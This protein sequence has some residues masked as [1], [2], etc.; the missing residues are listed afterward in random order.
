MLTILILIASIIG[1]GGKPEDADVSDEE[2]ALALL[3]QAGE[4]VVVGEAEQFEEEILPSFQKEIGE[5]VDIR[6][7][8]LVLETKSID[9]VVQGTLIRDKVDITSTPVV[10]YSVEDVEISDFAIAEDDTPLSIEDWSPTGEL[11]IENRKPTI[12]VVF[13]HPIVPIRQLGDPITD[14]PHMRIDPQAPGIFRWYGTRVLSF[15]PDEPLL[16]QRVYT[17]QISKDIESLG[18]KQL[19]ED[20][21]FSFTTEPLGVVDF[22]CGTF[23]DYWTNLSNVPPDFANTIYIGFNQP[24]DMNFV[25]QFIE[26]SAGGR[27]Y[28]F[29]VSRPRSDQQNLVENLVDR[30]L[31]LTLDRGVPK[32]TDVT[33]RFVSGIRSYED[34][35]P[36]KTEITREY[37][38]LRPLEYQYFNT[39]SYSFPRD[40]RGTIN[41]VFLIF[42]QPI[43]EDDA[44]GYIRTS[45]D[46][47]D[48]ADHIK[49]SSNVVRIDNLP[50]VYES[51]YEI[52]IGGGL[53]DVYG[54][55]LS[56]DEKISIRVP[57]APYYVKFPVYQ[58]NDVQM[59]ML[60]SQFAPK[61]I[62]EFQNIDSG[63]L[64]VGNAAV[65]RG[66][67]GPA[68][69][70]AWTEIPFSTFP[71]NQ[72]NFQT[73][74][75]AGYTDAY[76][77]WEID[78]PGSE[79]YPY[80]ASMAVQITDIGITVK[81]AYNSIL[82]WATSLS[83]AEAVYP[84]T[85]TLY[86]ANGETFSSPV[87]RNGLAAFELSPGQYRRQFVD[88]YGRPDFL[89]AVESTKGKGDS[90][91]FR[92]SQSHSPY[93][94]SV[95]STKQPGRIEDKQR[96]VFMFTDRGLYKPGEKVTF[97]GV[98]WIQKLD[99]FYP[100][101][102]GYK[103]EIK[104]NP[105][106][107]EVIY[108][109]TGTT[110]S[111]GGYFGSF[112]VPEDL[113]PGN[114]QIIYT[115][116]GDSQYH[117][118]GFQVAFFRRLNFQVRIRK[119]DRP[120]FHGDRI[121]LPAQASYLA[122]GAMPEASY[123]F[124]FT[125]QPVGFV[126]P[127]SMWKDYR[128]GPVS[129]ESARN[130]SSGSGRLNALGAATLE[131]ETTE[132]GIVGKAYQYSAE[133]TVE[134][135]DRQRVSASSSAIVHPGAFYIGL[136]LDSGTDG[137][138]STFVSAKEKS[139]AEVVLAQ[140]DGKPYKSDTEIEAVLI[141]Q[142][143]KSVQQRGVYGNLNTRY[144][145][146]SEEVDTQT[147]R[148]R[149]VPVSFNFTPPEAGRYTLK[150]S[151]VD[152]KDRVI[153]TELV[154]YATGSSWV[155]WSTSNDSDINLV[156]DREAYDVG[157]VA[158]LM[159]QSPIPD[160]DY[161]LT[162]EREGIFEHRIVS[163]EGS[164]SVID[165]P[166]TGEH[167]P[168]VYVSLTAV[169]KREQTPASY[170]DPDLG[171][172]KNYYGITA[173]RVSTRPKELD[174]EIIPSKGAYRPGDEAE[175]L[176]RVTRDGKP[177]PGAEVTFLAVDRGVLDLIDY[178]VPDPIA[179][180]Y[181]ESH[182]PLGVYGDDSRRLLLAPVTYDIKN[183][184]GGDDD[185]GGKL[186]RREDFVPLAVFEPF[187]HTDNKGYV[188]VSFTLPDTLTTYRAT[189][190]AFEESRLGLEEEEFLVQN[191][192]NVRTALPRR[193]RYRDTAAAGVVLQNLDNV[194]H[195]VTVSLETT[196]LMLPGETEKTVTVPGGSVY[197]VPFLLSADR[198]GEFELK[199]TILSDVLKEELIDTLIVERPLVREA[200]TT[201]G[202]AT[203][204][205]EDNISFFEEGLVLPSAIASNFG[206]LRIQLDSTQIPYLNK[207]LSDLFGY[208]GYSWVMGHGYN[209]LAG[210]LF[211]E[212]ADELL[213]VSMERVRG[214]VREY[215]EIAS[216]YQ[217]SDGGIKSSHRSRGSSLY[218]SLQVAHY[219]ALAREN[220]SYDPQT[221]NTSALISYLKTQRDEKRI[222]LHGLS[223][224]LYIFSLYGETAAS[225]I[226]ATLEENGDALGI[227]G[228]SYLALS[229]IELGETAKAEEIFRRLKNFVLIGTQSVDVLETY[230]TRYYYDS[231]VQQI[232]LMLQIA[233]LLGERPDT[234]QRFVN[235]V[236]ARSSSARWSSMYDKTF[237]VLAMHAVYKK[238]TAEESNFEARVVLNN[239]L[240]GTDSFEGLSLQPRVMDYQLQ[241]DPLASFKRDALFP[242]RFEK[243]GPGN[244]FYATTLTYALPSEIVIARDEGISV[245]VQIE[246]LS[247][248]V[249]DGDN[250]PLG[251]TFK[252]RIHIS[253]SKR[254]ADLNLTV[255]VPSGAEIIDA[256][257]TTTSA[258]SEAGG[259]GSNTTTRETVYGDEYSFSGAWDWYYRPNMIIYD[260][261]VVYEWM[262]FHRGSKEVTFLF[263]TTTPGIY[264][265]PPAMA[266]LMFEP[267]VFGRS[268][269]RI[270]R[271]E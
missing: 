240:L 234:V 269:G 38:T 111:S 138:W 76:V 15:E 67:Y 10:Y 168:V 47:T 191:P 228:L 164:A 202:S 13:S 56:K 3:D 212:V 250:L 5:A 58:S 179:Y 90:A 197:E 264:P 196:G 245:H 218:S 208:Y 101:Q 65:D 84:A 80:K 160:A 1:C 221:L 69:E 149:G 185:D 249:I 143:W 86:S 7:F 52:Y 265:T 214:E 77:S 112:I 141:H 232:S 271:I 66:L 44:A 68:D 252:A 198:E 203:I 215:F 217:F 175:V 209:A 2:Q 225:E 173:L 162:V 105:W 75:L 103:I 152:K 14:F 171:K 123:T 53:T 6:S 247:G 251:E 126:P 189:A 102:G 259:T 243:E 157:D 261:F 114:Y 207:P 33:V 210:I 206:S 71:R 128:F 154:F 169:S 187:L 29:S 268:E 193:L 205:A 224:L 147:I 166:I 139:K 227:S 63:R 153:R 70:I 88:T 130:L 258:F 27:A 104:E 61:L 134:D 246:D 183:L 241:D 119:P 142:Q 85:A 151:T 83:T 213:K 137:W 158:R 266:E 87:D 121:S 124:S 12:H 59:R 180:F 145:L 270:Y 46:L 110:T 263:R 223:Y 122:G 31:V 219:A 41:P 253:S 125:R 161:L 81:Q 92:P 16:K 11:P 231:A 155:R 242:I 97:R 177:V 94:F 96:R 235:T 220:G 135:I 262:D 159:V 98:E 150:L 100:F 140:P 200:F 78:N 57:A 201:I 22:R 132:V 146:V 28:P 204:E 238:E 93:R 257:F 99:D 64:R 260:N 9:T 24:V 233:A 226:D 199:F 54:Q 34:Y 229:Y 144:S 236:H 42:N 17:V 55:R 18:G 131:E 174:I 79:K 118:A 244:L 72:A 211:P 108:S 32:D 60:E 117:S 163:L 129:Y 62:Y 4:S 190:V 239:E 127:G 116:E 91:Q 172:P 45:F 107:D 182:F 8:E 74:D 194:G 255:P 178:H 106:A 181:R 49:V 184:Q 120:Y 48:L 248:N 222:S 167:I 267:E 39:Y 148:Y 109:E 25:T 82:V 156:P 237:A 37:H 113:K 19:G 21:T 115:R 176:I 188:K 73:I 95:Y 20:F 43:R 51:E 256:A 165:V 35:A 50:V 89:V 40:P 36:R 30:S 192:I 230:E 136:K 170:Y 26:I 133:I 216:R 23:D 195:E 186:K 254:R